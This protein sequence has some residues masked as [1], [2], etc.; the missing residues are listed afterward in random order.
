MIVHDRNTAGEIGRAA[1]ARG[2]SAAGGSVVAVGD[3]EFSQN[4]VVRSRGFWY[5]KCC[6][7]HR[8]SA[9]SS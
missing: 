9:L 1:I 2:V 5:R 3:Y 6:E 8:G 7:Q 4:G